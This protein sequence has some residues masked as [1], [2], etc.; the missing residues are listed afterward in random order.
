MIVIAEQAACAGRAIAVSQ[1]PHTRRPAVGSRA[2]GADAEL[3]GRSS[4]VELNY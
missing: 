3:H 2:L 1:Q 4:I